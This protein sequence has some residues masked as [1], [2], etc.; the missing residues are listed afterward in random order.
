MLAGMPLVSSPTCR[1]G[2]A[3]GL[4]ARVSWARRS[5]SL[6]TGDLH[7]VLRNTPHNPVAENECWI[8]LVETSTTKHTGDPSAEHEEHRRQLRPGG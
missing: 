6:R 1:S 8:V 5:V 3:V 7:V 4:R 2:V